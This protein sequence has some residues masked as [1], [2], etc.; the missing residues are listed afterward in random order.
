MELNSA[1]RYFVNPFADQCQEFS[2]GKEL[3]EMSSGFKVQGSRF[4]VE[5]RQIS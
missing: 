5:I 2:L 4:R 3:L 1:L